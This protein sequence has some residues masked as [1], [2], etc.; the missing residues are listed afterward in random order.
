MLLRTDVLNEATPSQG[1]GTITRCA[2]QIMLCGGQCE[3]LMYVPKHVSVR[4]S[5]APMRFAVADHAWHMCVP[6]MDLAGIDH[7]GVETGH[8]N[9][10]SLVRGSRVLQ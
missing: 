4:A 3:Q 9:D 5:T 6:H 1:T 8:E 10:C 7:V 2:L